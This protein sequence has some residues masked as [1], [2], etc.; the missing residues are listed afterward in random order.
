LEHKTEPSLPQNSHASNENSGETIQPQ[1]QTPLSSGIPKDRR[2]RK[3]P[4]WEPAAVIV[5]IGLLLVN[6]F[7]GCQTKK[8]A[9][10]AKSAAETAS[11]QL[12]MADRPWVK[13]TVRSASDFMF[14]YGGFSWG[15]IIRAEN[16][17]RSV[18]TAIFPQT[19][20]IA[21]HGADLIDGP[22]Q[23]AY[24]L[25]DEVFARFERVKNNPSVWGIAIFPG[26]CADIPTSPILWQSQIKDATFDGGGGLSQCVTPMLIGCIEYHNATSEKPHKTWFVYTLIHNDDPALPIAARGFFSLGKTIPNANMVLI[27]DSQFAD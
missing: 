24:E 19:K 22:R 2:K 12:E 25:C 18:A 11:R 5:A 10:A 26:D 4:W 15:V 20:L 21:V 9:M 14:N 1:V 3:T 16:V 17:G 6:W 13:D 23:K 27:K 7:Q 8:A